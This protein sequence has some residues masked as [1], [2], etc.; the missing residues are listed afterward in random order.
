MKSFVKFASLFSLCLVCVASCTKSTKLDET[1]NAIPKNAVSVTAINLPSLMQKADFEVVKQM[2][3]YKDMVDSAST[4]N[5]AIAEIMRD[6]KKSGVDFTKNIYL[7]QD[8]NPANDSHDNTS[9]A[10]LLSLSDADAFEKMLQAGLNSRINAQVREKDG[11]KYLVS[12]PEKHESGSPDK[13]IDAVIGGNTDGTYRNNREGGDFSAYFKNKADESIAKNENFTKLFGEQHDIYTYMNFDKIA[14]NP[15]MKAGAGMM[16]IDPKALKGNYMSGYADFEKGQIVGKS[17]YNIN[18]ELRQS[19]GL[20]FKDNVKTDFSKYLKGNDIGFAATL[21]LDMK[22][23]KEILNANPQFRIML[24]Q[25]KSDKFT[26]DDIFKAF[27]GDIVIAANPKAGDN[28]KWNGMIGFKLNDKA[29][30]EKLVNFLVSQNALASEGNGVYRFGGMADM[31][32]SNYVENGK[33]AF[34]DDVVFLGDAATIGNL[35]SGSGSVSSDVK[36][37]LNKNIFGLYTNFSKIF[38]DT[39]GTS[40]EN[41]E[42]LKDIEITELKMMMNGTSGEG[43]MKMKDANENSLKSLMK[44]MNRLYLKNKTDKTKEGINSEKQEI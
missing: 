22:G 43:I 8:F 33:L 37:V 12:A 13:H 5:A 26:T 1:A 9:G 42:G 32:S 14:D 4:K 15:Q 36:D 24:E 40:R 11:I 10:I 6:P 35:K 16:N 29:T 30:M 17:S 2:E 25:A 39:D 7:V 27:D 31:M 18:K 34:V 19:W 21:A 28:A 38:A 23:M 3:F 41:R 44:A 20:M